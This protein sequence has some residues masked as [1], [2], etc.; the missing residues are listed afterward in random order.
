MEAAL[1][2]HSASG[3]RLY[4]C[5]TAAFHTLNL[6][7]ASAT[8]PNGQQKISWNVKGERG[9]KGARGLKGNTGATGATGATG[10]TGAT[11]APGPKGDTGA[12]GAQGAKGDTG[13]TGA[14]G[15]PGSLASAYL[16]AYSSLTQTVTSNSDI[17]F[18]TLTVAPVGIS[19]KVA[20]NAFTVSNAGKYLVTFV[21]ATGLTAPLSAQLT[22][23]GTVVG[24]AEGA[25]FSR[26][27]SLS[28]GDVVTVRSVGAQS[29]LVPPGAGITIVRIS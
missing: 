7:S 19:T 23:N 5:V 14:T 22:V 16:D 21:L 13:A 15:P 11:G 3:G 18:D 29:A 12:T 24:P 26:I 9:P 10:D 28:V 25:S 1:K 6:S 17:A 2:A 8:C 4:A 20:D 27:L